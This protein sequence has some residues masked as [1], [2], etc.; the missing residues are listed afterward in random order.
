M[1]FYLW[2]SDPGCGSLWLLSLQ[3]FGWSTPQ[4]ARHLNPHPRMVQSI[5]DRSGPD[6]FAARTGQLRQL[7]LS[8]TQ[9]L[10]NFSLHQ[11]KRQTGAQPRLPLM[12]SPASLRAL[13][14]GLPVWLYPLCPPGSE[15][16]SPG[17]RNC[18]GQHSARTAGGR[19]SRGGYLGP[20]TKQSE[21]K[22]GSWW[23][24]RRWMIS[25]IQLF[26]QFEKKLAPSQMSLYHLKQSGT[27]CL[28]C[29]LV[30]SSAAP[31]SSSP[32]SSSAVRCVRGAVRLGGFMSLCTLCRGF[33]ASR[34]SPVPGVW[35]YRV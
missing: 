3:D 27:T 21:T 6:S 30:S 14:S 31:S 4:P 35:W 16:C 24:L 9:P 8:L 11:P 17:R 1:W 28:G 34:G 2:P 7:Y 13:Q 26:S 20:V 10:L 23:G 29:V 25:I 22:K 15:A 19:S 18:F 5:L 32:S 12:A 33:P